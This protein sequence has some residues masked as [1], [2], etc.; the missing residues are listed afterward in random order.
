[1]LPA[2]VAISGYLP[3]GLSSALI[4]DAG[5]YDGAIGIASVTVDRSGRVQRLESSRINT[6]SR[7][8]N[9]IAT[10]IG[11]SFFDPESVKST[12]TDDQFVIL[13]APKEAPCFDA[14]S[15]TSDAMARPRR[16]GDSFSSPAVARRTDPIVS[17]DVRQSLKKDDPHEFYIVVDS[18]VAPTGCLRGVQLVKQSPI[19]AVNASALA[20]LS[21]W[22]FRPATEDGIPVA[23]EYNLTIRFRMP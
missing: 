11:L 14:T 20:A 1:M 3:P 13:K 4:R 7:C 10:M 22:K 2:Q 9:A 15:L 12:P 19:A 18:V 6:P 23:A 5:C 16:A 17:N 8:L 21:Q